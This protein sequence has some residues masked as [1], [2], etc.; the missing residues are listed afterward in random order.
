MSFATK[1]DMQVF[2]GRGNFGLWQQRMLDMLIFHN[3]DEVLSDE[4]P[5]EISERDWLV[6]DKKASSMIR[7]CLGPNSLNE[8]KRDFTASAIWK[9]K[10]G[11]PCKR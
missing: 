2:D 11:E 4:R 6:L 9:R 3:Y 5:A 1:M 8:M 7:L 10:A